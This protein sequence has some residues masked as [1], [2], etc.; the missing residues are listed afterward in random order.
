MV[1]IPMIMES[2]TMAE[3]NR[4]SD[5]H[6]HT[7]LC[8]HATGEME[9]YV[10]AALEKGLT[11]LVFLEHFETGIAYFETTWLTE[12]DFHLY[13][14]EGLR[15]QR[16]YRDRIQVETGV[17]IGFNPA[18]IEEIQGFIHEWNWARVG[19]SYHYL[20]VAGEPHINMLSRK[21]VNI[22]RIAGYGPD[23]LLTGYYKGLLQ[24]VQVIDADVVCHLDAGL[25]H[26]A[27]VTCQESHWQQIGEILDVMAVRDMALELNSSGL[28]LR[29]EP[30]PCQ[31]IVDMAGRRGLRMVLG[32]DAHSPEQVG[33]GFAQISA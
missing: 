2:M 18:R 15:L 17:E 9:D 1:I 14:D 11:H 32:S 21:T 24:A 33:R 29:G 23:L 13:R 16:K 20:P 7:R 3:L 8:H 6:V 10:R 28:A 30:F 4:H 31:R 26:A 19:L 25:R 12:A 5:G 22:D 27:K